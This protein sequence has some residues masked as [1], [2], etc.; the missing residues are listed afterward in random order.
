MVGDKLLLLDIN[1]NTISKKEIT[2][3]SISWGNTLEN[4]YNIDV[5]PADQFLVK[6][7][8]SNFTITH[9]VCTYCGRPWAPCG[10]Y[11]CDNGCATC[12]TP[13]FK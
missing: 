1:T 12:D 5:E 13:G 8:G 3:L 9:N 2:N 11:W 10:N 6:Y 7:S 4:V